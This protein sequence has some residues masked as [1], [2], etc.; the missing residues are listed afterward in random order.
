[1]TGVQT[2]ALPISSRPKRT[3][4]AKNPLIAGDIHSYLSFQP[5][6]AS[7][8]KTSLIARGL[9]YYLSFQVIDGLSSKNFSYR[10]AY[11]SLHQERASSLEMCTI[12]SSKRGSNQQL[13][14]LSLDMFISLAAKGLNNILLSLALF[15]TT[16]RFNISGLYQQTFI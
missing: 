10:W 15:I 11:S 2:C 8:A 7:A 9:Y 12:I 16:Q 1:M 14:F 6:K 13:L 3:S 5:R 4:A